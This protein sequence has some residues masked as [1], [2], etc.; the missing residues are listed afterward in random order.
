MPCMKLQ[1][2]QMR[3]DDEAHLRVLD[4]IDH[5]LQAAVDVADC[6]DRVDDLLVFEDEVQDE[7]LRQNRMLRP[8]RDDGSLHAFLPDAAAVAWRP[9]LR[10]AP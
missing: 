4:A 5:G 2:P 8:E 6:R 1:M 10:A 7:R 3:S 9:W